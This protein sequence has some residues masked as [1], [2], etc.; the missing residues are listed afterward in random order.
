MG[1]LCTNNL[2]EMEKCLKVGFFTIFKN[3]SM[4]GYQ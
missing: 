2:R 4:H 1:E 3:N